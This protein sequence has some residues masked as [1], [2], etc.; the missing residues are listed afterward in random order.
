MTLPGALLDRD[1]CPTAEGLAAACGTDR[2]RWD[3][4]ACWIETTYGVTGEPLYFGRESGWVL[5]FRRSGKALLT[6]LPLAGGGLRALIVVGP[7][8]WE[9]VATA[10]LS[11]PIRAAWAAA[12]PYPDGRWLWP[13]VTDD[14]VVEDIERLVAI[15]SPPPRQP[16]RPRQPAVAASG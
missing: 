1:A 13:V 9:A 4:L 12:H 6:L 7:S 11:E 10:D 15:K 5:R 16:R 3:R 8:A 14:T 2:G